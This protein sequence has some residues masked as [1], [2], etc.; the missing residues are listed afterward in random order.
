MA[1]YLIWFTVGLVLVITEM[2]SGTF[3]LL[4]LGVGA[5]AGGVAAWGGLGI[6]PQSMIA[7]L[8]ALAGTAWVWHL[9]RGTLKDQMPSLDIGQFAA[10]ESWVSRETGLAR[11]K[12]RDTFWDA[13]IEG[14]AE[15]QTGEL[16]TIVAVEGNTLRLS[17]PHSA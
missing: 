12:Y 10:F 11:V 9:R 5:F 7:V 2:V 1:D 3:F 14:P 17:K 13:K 6:W 15:A 8:V 4:V 16:F